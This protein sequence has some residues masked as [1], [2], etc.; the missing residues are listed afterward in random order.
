MT[1]QVSV[2]TTYPELYSWA[3]AFQRNPNADQARIEGF[4]SKTT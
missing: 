3:H 1:I 4:V 2:H